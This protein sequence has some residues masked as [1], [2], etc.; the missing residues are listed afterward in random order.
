MNKK[1]NK[2]SY[3][4]LLALMKPAHSSQHITPI[5]G[6]QSA[7]YTNQ[8]CIAVGTSQLT[9]PTSD[10]FNCKDVHPCIS[11]GEVGDIT[12]FCSNLIMMYYLIYKVESDDLVHFQKV[13]ED[14]KLQKK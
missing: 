5:S 14:S 13:F 1:R 3:R 11:C 2:K 10:T 4:D 7:Y 6:Q 9:P 12:R 8:A